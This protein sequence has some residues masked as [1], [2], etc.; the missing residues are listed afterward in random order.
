MVNPALFVLPHVS[1]EC[2]ACYIRFRN[3]QNTIFAILNS[4]LGN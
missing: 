2:F 1:K 4:M 3:S